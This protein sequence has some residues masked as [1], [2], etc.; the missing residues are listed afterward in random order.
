MCERQKECE[1]LAW[2]VVRAGQR[3]MD[4]WRRTGTCGGG[5]ARMRRRRGRQRLRQWRRGNPECL[6]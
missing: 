6:G 3:G 5:D 4:D 1:R 2:A